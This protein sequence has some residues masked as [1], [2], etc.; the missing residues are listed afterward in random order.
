MAAIG[1][2]E[3]VGLEALRDLVHVS[4]A[5]ERCAGEAAAV[6]EPYGGATERV[7]Y[8]RLL[9][10]FPSPAG[11]A[12]GFLRLRPAIVALDL[13]LAAG[14]SEGNGS[15]W[16]PAHI[17]ARTLSE[18]AAP[19]ELLLDDRLRRRLGARVRCEEVGELGGVRAWRLL[20]GS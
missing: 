6:L 1:F 14:L 11:A 8:D 13:D 19:G 16:G 20:S 4:R 15:A 17:A 2:C 18:A 10:V 7:L 3:F 9:A 12:D 5:A